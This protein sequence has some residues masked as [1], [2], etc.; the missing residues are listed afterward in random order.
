MTSWFGGSVKTTEPNP[1]DEFLLKDKKNYEIPKEELFEKFKKMVT[2]SSDSW[3]KQVKEEKLKVWT[4]E[5][6]NS[7]VNII[8]VR[9]EFEV[10]SDV[11]F[12]LIRDDEYFIKTTTDEMFKDWK[13]IDIINEE[14]TV[15]YCNLITLNSKITS[16]LPSIHQLE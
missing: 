11:L 5:A 7:K 2:S 1:I 15:S 14:N 6:S 13:N 16:K 4:K 9:A 8:K 3:T 10:K 12:K